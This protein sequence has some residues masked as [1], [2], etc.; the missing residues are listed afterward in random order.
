ME[1]TL[2]LSEWATQYRALQ[3][4]A[5]AVNRM[6]DERIRQLAQRAGLD[7]SIA[8]IHIH[9]ALMGLHY[10]KPWPNVDYSLVRK[11]RWLEETKLFAATRLVSRWADRIWIE[12]VKLNG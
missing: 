5:E 11:A 6:V 9:N 12:E 7:R 3:A 4:R 1:K 2:T 8:G 10:G